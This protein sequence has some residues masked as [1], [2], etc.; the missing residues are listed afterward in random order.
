[1]NRFSCLLVLVAIPSVAFACTGGHD[2][3]SA[4]GTNPI[5]AEDSVEDGEACGAVTCGAG[6]VCC[7][8]SCGICTGPDESCIML[9]C[10]GEPEPKPKPEPKPEPCIKTGCSG[11]VCADQDIATTCEWQPHYACY[12]NAICERQA[13]G[14]CGFRATKELEECLAENA[15]SSK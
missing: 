2:D 4:T 15:S 14:E 5:V 13:D 3:K 11:H 9:A 1:M 10:D 7:N 8:A 12:Q 6:Q